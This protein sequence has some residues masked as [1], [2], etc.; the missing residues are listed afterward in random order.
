MLS[1]VVKGKMMTIRFLVRLA[2][3]VEAGLRRGRR[4]LPVVP[5][6]RTSLNRMMRRTFRMKVR[7]IGR[8]GFTGDKRTNYFQIWMILSFQKN[9]KKRSNRRRS[10]SGPPQFDHQ[11]HLPILLRLM[12]WQ[13]SNFRKPLVELPRNGHTTQMIPHHGSS[14]L[15]LLLQRN[16]GGNIRRKHI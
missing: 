6:M 5:T 13:I 8:R 10:E 4:G 12:M 9:Q 1:R 11:S 16:K 3:V 7:G 15:Q 14:H 2:G